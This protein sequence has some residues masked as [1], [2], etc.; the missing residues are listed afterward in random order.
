MSVYFNPVNAVYLPKY[1]YNAPK[2]LPLRQSLTTDTVSFSGKIKVEDVETQNIKFSENYIN[3]DDIPKL[4]KVFN[5]NIKELEKNNELTP[6]KVQAVIN[7]LVPN[8]NLQVKEIPESDDPDSN[9]FAQFGFEP[10]EKNK[11]IKYNMFIDFN[12]TNKKFNN[13]PSSL[14]HE[15]T[16]FLQSQTKEENDFLKK[17]ISTVD[18][19]NKDSNLLLALLQSFEYME[20]AITALEIPENEYNSNIKDLTEIDLVKFIPNKEYSSYLQQQ[21]DSANY[22]KFAHKDILKFYAISS[23]D[24]AQAHLEG[25]K[26]GKETDEKEMLL[27]CSTHTRLQMPFV[28][29][30]LNE[31][32][33]LS[34]EKEDK[35]FII[36]YETRLSQLEK[37]Y[38]QY[39][40]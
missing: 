6:N 11:T 15:F 39:K 32:K 3:P 40:S 8:N 29:H 26:A 4:V 9:T 21:P 16:H 2:I 38:N 36:A 1:Q 34:L 25:Y 22:K 18:K 31:L 30:C 14:A 17:A 28:K 33:K 37:E 10:D 24:E 13:L 12:N 23:F 19:E 5:Q 7:E 27:N 20:I 35:E